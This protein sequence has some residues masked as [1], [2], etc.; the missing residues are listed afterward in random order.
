MA[1]VDTKIRE[2]LHRTIHS[3]TL[4]EIIFIFLISTMKQTT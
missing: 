3:E 1:C 4:S 2:F